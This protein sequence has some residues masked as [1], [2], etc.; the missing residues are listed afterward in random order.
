M[1]ETD[2]DTEEK[3]EEGDTL[4]GARYQVSQSVVSLWCEACCN[5]G[6]WK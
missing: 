6:N 4:E 2:E 5:S 3:R 1:R